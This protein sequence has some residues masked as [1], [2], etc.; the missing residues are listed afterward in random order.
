MHATGMA[1][2]AF[3]FK[4]V[5]L[6]SHRRRNQQLIAEDILHG[7]YPKFMMQ[8]PKLTTET[9]LTKE[10][11]VIIIVSYEQIIKLQTFNFPERESNAE[12]ISF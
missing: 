6:I 12:E 8:M 9:F 11:S 1:F 7:Y 5:I 2:A 10:I 4:T 3:I